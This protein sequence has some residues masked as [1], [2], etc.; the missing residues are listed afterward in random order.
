MSDS[1][2]SQPASATAHEHPEDE[3]VHVPKGQSKLQFYLMVIV[4]LVILVAFSIT[5]AMMSTLSG[6]PR[7]A[8]FVSW[9]V[10]GRDPVVMDSPTFR[11]EKLKLNA[12]Q[13]VLGRP[14]GLATGAFDARSDEGVARFL[15]LEELALQSGMRVSDD[16]MRDMI[17][18]AFGTDSAYKDI[19]NSRQRVTPKLFE[20]AL[21][22]WILV[23]R[24]LSW[25]TQGAQLADPAVIE[26]EWL[27]GNQEY[28][29][30]Y[31]VVPSEAYRQH[32][33]EQLPADEELQAWFDAK[34]DFEKRRYFEGPFFTAEAT[35]LSLPQEVVPEKLVA[36]Y[37][38]KEDEDLEAAAKGYYDLYY[39]TRFVKPEEIRADEKD[40]YFPFEEV[41]DVCKVEVQAFN[42]M[43][44]WLLDLDKLRKEDAEI[45]L[46]AEAERLGLEHATQSEPLTRDQWLE[47]ELPWTGTFVVN[48]ILRSGSGT[49]GNRIVVDEN[50]LVIS[51][52]LERT[53]PSLPDFD[54]IRERVAEEWI[55][56]KMAQVAVL[57]LE[58]I[59][60]LL[61]NRPV[62]PNEMW[63]LVV[64]SEK[65]G[66][67][68]VE[69]GFTPQRRDYQGREESRTAPAGVEET[70]EQKIVR[71]FLYRNNALYQL[72]DG[73]V[74]TPRTH[75]N[76]EYALIVRLE[77]TRDPDLQ[78]K[79]GPADVERLEGQL[80]QQARQS[81]LDQSFGSLEWFK[82][83]MGLRMV[84]PTTGEP[85]L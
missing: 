80:G 29:F 43:N 54:T 72:K 78:T 76:D 21:A 6:D 56:E 15:I 12:I 83:E 68:A 1:K 8:T 73:Q 84:D 64:D 18:A 66:E 34:P 74:G 82:T 67:A 47:L 32:S 58:Q 13:D 44:L 41:Q 26:E 36:A 85:M 17:I 61:G 51:R 3:L 31:V 62:D 53:E 77:G 63:E 4:I 48:E 25:T 49:L 27:A 10:P 45:D 20:E 65:F 23:E 81:F 35:Y 11:A 55:K 50:A 70:D 33:E 69:L 59:R 60:D 2:S 16:E 24:F 28:A 37:P 79:I 9:E 30:D 7:G 46:A 71:E 38:P 52:V 22:R 5:P 40:L 75:V 14:L 42:S 39:T 19:I 57:R